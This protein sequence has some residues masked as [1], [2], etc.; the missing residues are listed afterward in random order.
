MVDRVRTPDYYQYL[1]DMARLDLPKNR[2]YRKLLWTLYKTPFKW[3]HPM[4]ENRELDGFELRK[5]YL[6]D[7]PN[8]SLNG[9]SDYSNVLEVLLAFSRRIEIDI[10]GEPGN[11]I[12]ERWFW[13]MLDNLGLLYFDDFNFDN[14]K[15]DRILSI[16]LDRKFS[17][18]GKGNIFLTKKVDRDLRTEEY[19]WQ[20]QHYMAEKYGS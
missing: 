10:M 15:V 12:I 8:S 18:S 19:W 13:L 3:I 6:R 2:N 11:D 16:W 4:D 17:K 1:C 9:C 14:A 7:F 20:M 5:E